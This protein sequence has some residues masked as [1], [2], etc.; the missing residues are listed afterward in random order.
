VRKHRSNKKM[1]I[2]TITEYE[3]GEMYENHI[4]RMIVERSE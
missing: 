4:D 2:E 1:S 3:L